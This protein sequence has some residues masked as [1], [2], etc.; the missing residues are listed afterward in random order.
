MM[1]QDNVKRH[2]GITVH[3]SV[4]RLIRSA[5]ALGPNTPEMDEN[6]GQP[7][8]ILS[9]DEAYDHTITADKPPD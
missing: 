8:Q 7:A 3:I 2:Y 9:Q 5:L 1:I 4:T 6:E